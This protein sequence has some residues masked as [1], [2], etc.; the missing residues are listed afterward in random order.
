MKVR[1]C[2]E[3]GVQ[4]GRSARRCPSCGAKAP[5]RAKAL[6]TVFILLLAGIMLWGY[7]DTVMG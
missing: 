2:P 6:T 5:R 7:L 4:I 3:C 1:S